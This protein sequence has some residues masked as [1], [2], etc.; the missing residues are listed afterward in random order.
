MSDDKHMTGQDRKPFDPEAVIDAMAPLLDLS[1]D[2]DYRP[3][4]ATNLLVTAR[5]AAVVLAAPL[6]DEAEPAPVFVA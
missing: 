5:F 6:D 2:P 1:I 4:I 3:G